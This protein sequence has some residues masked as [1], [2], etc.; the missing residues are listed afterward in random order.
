MQI[1]ITGKNLKVTPSLRDF[2]NKKITKLV[3]DFEHPVN[4][5]VIISVEKLQHIAEIIISG[6]HGRFYF[7]KDARDLYQAVESVVHSAN[8][9]IRKFKE[10]QKD[11]KMKPRKDA[12]PEYRPPVIQDRNYR[13]QK[14]NPSDIKPMTLEEAVLQ[15][16]F[17]KQ[18]I[19]IFNNSKGFRTSILIQDQ[20]YFNLIVHDQPLLSHFL[21]WKKKRKEYSKILLYY[22]NNKIKTIKKQ[23]LNPE[24]L[25]QTDA[26]QRILYNK[27]MVSIVFRNKETEK[28]DIIF[29][30]NK[31]YLGYYEI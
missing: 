19:L 27:N 21:F 12:K 24:L 25:N 31:N 6:D 8:V 28:T 15:L 13:L 17:L 1:N 30:I 10:K 9:S 14:L 4:C 5:E 26:L 20:N 11:R 23:R 2:I 29:R 16:K 7:K 18:D 22:S 3:N